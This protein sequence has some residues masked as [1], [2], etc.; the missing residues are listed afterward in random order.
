VEDIRADDETRILRREN[1]D[2]A[3][4][5]PVQRVQRNR[6]PRGRP[7]GADDPIWRLVGTGASD[8]PGDVSA[9]KHTYLADAYAD[10]H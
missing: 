8:G 5:R 2:M 10:R 1:E 7:A 9:Q 3:I 4:V 6:R